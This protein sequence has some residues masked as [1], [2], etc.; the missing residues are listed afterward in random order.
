M[1]INS[2]KLELNFFFYDRMVPHSIIM[3]NLK[4]AWLHGSIIYI[5]SLTLAARQVHLF[6]QMDSLIL[7]KTLRQ[8]VNKFWELFQLLLQYWNNYCFLI[9]VHMKF[10]AISIYIRNYL[11]MDDFQ[12]IINT[13]TYLPRL[14]ICKKPT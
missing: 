13:C 3:Q 7:G 10:V 5:M 8:M 12:T 6:H 2:E 11:K 9:L 14:A 4:N 1:S